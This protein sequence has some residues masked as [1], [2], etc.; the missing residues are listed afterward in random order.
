MVELDPLPTDLGMGNSMDPRVLPEE[1]QELV[2]EGKGQWMDRTPREQEGKESAREDDPMD[3][4]PM[5]KH[6]RTKECAE[7]GRANLASLDPRACVE[8]A[9]QRGWSSLTMRGL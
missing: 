3:R 1:Q 8:G 2:Q 9:M 6:R 7:E 4:D 5:Q